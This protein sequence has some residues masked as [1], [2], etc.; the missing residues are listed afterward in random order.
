LDVNNIKEA[1]AK[2]AKIASTMFKEDAL[3]MVVIKKA[4]LNK[5]V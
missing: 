3:Y 2:F 1:D 4:L 5:V